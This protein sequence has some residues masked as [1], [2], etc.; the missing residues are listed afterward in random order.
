MDFAEAM[1]SNKIIALADNQILRLI[2]EETNR[3][4][5]MDV[6]EN[7][8]SER[9]TLKKKK[10]SKENRQRI[11]ELQNLIY[12]FMFVPEYVTIVIEADSHYERLFYKGLFLNGKKYVRTSCSAS[13]GRMSTVVFVEEKISEKILKKM[14]NDRDLQK[15]LVPSKYNAYLGTYG[16]ATKIVSTPK[17]CIIPDCHKNRKVRVNWVEET[18]WD[19]DDI[20]EEKE[21]DIDFNLFDGNGLI[22]PKKATEWAEELGLDYLPAQWCIRAPF[23]KGMLSVFDFVEFAK[24]INNE[25]YNIRTL[26]GEI[27]DIRDADV[28]L[29]ESQFKLWDSYNSY[30]EYESYSLKNGLSWGVSLHTPKKDKDVLELNYQFLQTL[31]LSDEDVVKLCEMTVKYFEGITSDNIMYTL[32]F[33]LGKNV[34]IEKLS[35]QLKYGDNYWVNALMFDHNLINDSYIREK[36]FDLVS[37]RIKDA[38]IGKIFVEGNFQVIVPDSFAFMQ[39]ACGLEVEGLLKSGEFYSRYWD[40][41]KVDTVDAMRSPLTHISEHNIIKIK[42][43]DTMDKWFKYYYT[44]MIANCQDEHTL[45]FSG[46]DYDYDIIATTSNEIMKKG[47]HKNQLPIVYQ[48]PKAE[49]FVI[50][51]EQLYFSDLFTFGSIIGSITNKTTNIYSLLPLFDRDSTECHVLQNRLKMGCKLQSAQIDKAKIGKEVKGIPSCWDKYE[52]PDEENLTEIAVEEIK[53]NNSLLCDK[54]PYFFI[55]LYRETYKKYKNYCDGYDRLC[56]TM[57]K[58]SL[59]E[60]KNLKRRTI[61]QRDFL[62]NFNKYLPVVDSPC[63]MNKICHYMESINFNIKAKLKRDKTCDFYRVYTM[64]NVA[65]NDLNYQKVKVVVRDLIS[66]LKAKNTTA[67]QE[68][69]KDKVHDHKEIK[70]GLI[71]TAKYKL[72]EISSDKFEI[73]NYLVSIFYEEFPSY[74]KSILFQLCGKYMVENVKQNKGGKVFIPILDENGS[75]NF[76]N[77]KFKIEE[78][79]VD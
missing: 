62:E 10:N 2:R 20:I 11:K 41:K 28:I 50:N 17:V 51:Q 6:I 71:R 29:T 77:Q 14:D 56:K 25:N 49:K 73:T 26:Y 22:S 47:V 34:D 58:I 19:R 44:G 75:V 74:N 3:K 69:K 18:S 79:L 48:P 61:E 67:V 54:H 60:L 53:F 38:C 46:S 59:S 40:D 66:V 24:E 36:I 4:I 13:Q 39:H 37:A 8:Y 15:P 65:K 42:K 30:E 12:D 52:K 31:N 68:N 43:S 70:D 76:L 78:I 72:N 21:V 32:L 55:Y 63:E 27:F 1:E 35:Q 23:T 33:L 57:F 64:K 9:D 7:W 45:R 16:S 5:S